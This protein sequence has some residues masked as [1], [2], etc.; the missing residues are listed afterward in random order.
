MNPIT[1]GPAVPTA[2]QLRARL[3][4]LR[5]PHRRGRLGD[6]LTDVYLL[7]LLVAMYTGMSW[8][9]LHRHLTTLPPATAADNNRGWLMIAAM[10]VLTG[11]TWHSLRAFGPMLVRPAVN[12]WCL[13]TPVARP[14]WLRPWLFGLLTAGAVG[15]AAAAVVAAGGA[16][17]AQPWRYTAVGAGI[18][19]ALAA[20]AVTAQTRPVSGPRG[21]GRGHAADRAGV[22]TMVAGTLSV[23]AVLAVQALGVPLPAPGL[24]VPAVTAPAALVAAG[25]AILANRSLPRLDRVAL[26][27]GVRLAEAMTAAAVFMDVS[28]LSGVLETRRWQRVGRVSGRALRAAG[29]TGVLL[30]GE[31]R[32][33]ARRPA[34]L[35][36]W[37]G[38]LLVPYGCALVLPGLVHGARIVAAY[39]AVSG[40]AAG[41]RTVCR[42]AV[43]RRMIGG[44]DRDIIAA[45][46]ALPGAG[47][48]SWWLLTVPAVGPAGA[49][50]D[51]LL[52]VGVLAAVYRGA[53]RPPMVY[54]GAVVDTP[55]GLIPVGLLQQVVRGP[56]LVAA[57][58]VTQAVLS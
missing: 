25:L 48:A 14:R 16:L 29:R 12:A 46:L 26:T 35:G 20:A 28:L 21:A 36:R 24:P 10:V 9:A 33:Q 4:R 30:R 19:V 54:D 41:L 42:S 52:P 37:A 32:R 51:V 47:V 22:L 53:R 8:P 55:A 6:L 39:L 7:I 2:R 23:A 45:H 34:S 13:S 50:L 56:D 18:G 5:R 27:G 49:L 3:R 17:L 15:G 31:L 58:L 44:R 1:T 38:L 11:A 57:L 40:L 43:L